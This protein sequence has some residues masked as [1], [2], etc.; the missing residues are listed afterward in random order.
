MYLSNTTSMLSIATLAY[1]SVKHVKCYVEMSATAGL[2]THGLKPYKKLRV[3][4]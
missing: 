3:C 1:F 2:L 4:A